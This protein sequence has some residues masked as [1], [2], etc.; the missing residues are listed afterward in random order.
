MPGLLRRA[1][2]ADLS[3]TGA[4]SWGKLLFLEFEDNDCVD[5]ISV[6]L[7]DGDF[8]IGSLLNDGHLAA[9]QVIARSDSFR[10]GGKFDYIFRPY[11]DVNVNTIAFS[12]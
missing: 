12:G 2:Q 11:Q 3:I 1:L 9:G 7:R 4:N 5:G 8:D 6:A 10:N